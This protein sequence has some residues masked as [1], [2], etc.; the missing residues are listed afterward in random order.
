MLNVIISAVLSSCSN[1][2][3]KDLYFLLMVNC[4]SKPNIEISSLICSEVT[5]K[6]KTLTPC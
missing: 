5:G 1:V 6:A 2:L 4:C 3:S